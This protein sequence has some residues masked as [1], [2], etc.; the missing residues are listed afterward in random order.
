[1]AKMLINDVENKDELFSVIVSELRDHGIKYRKEK[2][3][4]TGQ[5]NVCDR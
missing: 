3:A 1:M 2:K 5:V 4:K